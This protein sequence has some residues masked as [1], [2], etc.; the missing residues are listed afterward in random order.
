MNSRYL[1]SRTFTI[2]ISTCGELFYTGNFM[3]LKVSTH[4]TIKTLIVLVSGTSAILQFPQNVIPR[5]FRINIQGISFIVY[6]QRTET[7][8][9]CTFMRNKRATTETSKATFRRIQTI[10]IIKLVNYRQ[11][12]SYSFLLS[13]LY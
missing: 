9:Q 13:Y 10:T 7:Y 1:I 3:A 12:S 8:V 4:Y 11:T 6:L 5:L 2:S